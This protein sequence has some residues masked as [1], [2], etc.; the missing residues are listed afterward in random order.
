MIDGTRQTIGSIPS[1]DVRRGDPGSAAS[2][3]V[4]AVSFERFYKAVA[5][6]VH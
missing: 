2:Q 4:D 3:V 5:H 6:E 1:L